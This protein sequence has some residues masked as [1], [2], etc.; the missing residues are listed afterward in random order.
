[1][2][3]FSRKTLYYGRNT[4]QNLLSAKSRFFLFLGSPA[5]PI[6]HHI[7]VAFC[8]LD[9]VNLLC[10]FST[11]NLLYTHALVSKIHT[12]WQIFGDFLCVED[13]SLPGSDFD[14]GRSS[15][16][17]CKASWWLG[18]H[19]S[20]E[21]RMR[22]SFLSK[23][24]RRALCPQKLLAEQESAS[25]QVWAVPSARKELACAVDVTALF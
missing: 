17:C 18:C 6:M 8:G 2:I 10:L 19:I 11:T 23:G 5:S 24:L 1:M 13:I 3:R 16:T 7:N 25:H 20:L 12:R 15:C 9:L 4:H 22:A 21:R 14:T